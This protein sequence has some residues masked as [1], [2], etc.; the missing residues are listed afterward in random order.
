MDEKLKDFQNA[1]GDENELKDVENEKLNEKLKMNGKLKRDEREARLENLKGVG[2][3]MLGGEQIFAVRIWLDP[4]KLVA[5]GVTVSDV[6]A[7]Q[8]NWRVQ[9][10]VF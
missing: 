7:A 8:N 10:I 5:S 2:Q 1:N 4:A 9:N 3:V 6:A